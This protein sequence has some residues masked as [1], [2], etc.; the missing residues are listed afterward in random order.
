VLLWVLRVLRVLRVLLGVLLWVLPAV[1]VVLL[2]VGLAVLVAVLVVLVLL[3]RSC[4]SCRY[5]LLIVSTRRENGWFPLM[6]RSTGVDA[7][8]DPV[9]APP[10]TPG[11]LF[12]RALLSYAYPCPGS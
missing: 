12:I 1:L 9:A 4:G 11:Q 3:V 7:P 5:C 2:A 6:A 8:E 10:R